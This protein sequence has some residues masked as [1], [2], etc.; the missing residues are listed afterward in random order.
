MNMTYFFFLPLGKTFVI[1]VVAIILKTGLLFKAFCYKINHNDKE[2]S[3][4]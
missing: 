2:R 3:K 4:T 1:I